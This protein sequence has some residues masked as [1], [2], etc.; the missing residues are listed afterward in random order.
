MN[1]A[2]AK[3]TLNI[4]TYFEWMIKSFDYEYGKTNVM[5]TAKREHNECFFFLYRKKVR[6]RETEGAASRSWTPDVMREEE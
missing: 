5:S 4:L 6:H 2:T 3:R 1:S